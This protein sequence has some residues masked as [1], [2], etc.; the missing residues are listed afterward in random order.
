VKEDLPSAIHS[1]CACRA[2][3]DKSWK[4][5]GTL[6]K[7]PLPLGEGRGEGALEMVR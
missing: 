5:Q 4:A 1:T 7:L 6:T 3:C 2:G